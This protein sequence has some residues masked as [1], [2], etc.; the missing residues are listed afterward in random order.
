MYR[1]NYT[2]SVKYQEWAKPVNKLIGKIRKKIARKIRQP[3]ITR[4]CVKKIKEPTAW[5]T[6]FQVNGCFKLVV[7][8]K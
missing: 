8:Y 7:G 4:G 5:A 2:L 3:M 6:R 1:L